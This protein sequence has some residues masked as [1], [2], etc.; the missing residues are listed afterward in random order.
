LT[1][2]HY[3]ALPIGESR[4]IH[5]LLTQNIPT[6]TPN[7]PTTKHTLTATPLYF[8]NDIQKH[9]SIPNYVQNSGGVRVSYG[10]AYPTPFESKASISYIHTHTHWG[11]HLGKA[12]SNGV[13]LDLGIGYSMKGFLTS[14]AVL[15]GYS[16]TDATHNLL[17]GY[18]IK[19]KSTPHSWDLAE[20]LSLQY[21]HIYQCITIIPR[22]LLTQTNV[23]LSSIY[24]D[25][26][27][28]L[29][30]QTD[31]KYFGFLDTLLSLRIQGQKSDCYCCVKPYV[32]LGWH[33]SSHLS[34]RD[35][36]S[37]LDNYTAC[38]C[39]F[40]TKTYCGSANRFF[41]ECG[42]AFSFMNNIDLLINS[43]TEMTKGDFIQAVNLGASWRF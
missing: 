19:A 7:C 33:K 12:D 26:P 29:N 8:R 37:K 10:I 20:S 14:L 34:N 17:I 24:E 4:A 41:M 27:K 16:Y 30:L 28:G 31:A 13:Y 11:N 6:C 36:H 39:S 23:Y 1:S 32:D 15:G 35:F 38:A 22:I 5:Y 18:P 42:I 40:S 9:K 21:T 25:K 2:E 3:G 43:R